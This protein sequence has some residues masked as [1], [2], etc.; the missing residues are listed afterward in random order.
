MRVVDSTLFYDEIFM[1]LLRLTI[2]SSKVDKFVI[3]EADRSHAGTPKPYNLERYWPLLF[4]WHDKIHYVKVTAPWPVDNA[5]VIENW[6][7]NQLVHAWEELSLEKDDIILLSDLDEIFRPETITRV[8]S[9]DHNCYGLYQPVFYFRFNY[10]CIDSGYSCAPK[11]LRY[12]HS[13]KLSPNE[14]RHYR[15]NQ[16]V[17]SNYVEYHHSGWHW[18]YLM[19]NAMVVNKIQQFAHQEFNTPSI[20]AS[21][22]VDS[23]LASGKDLYNRSY[24]N[25]SLVKVDDYFPQIITSFPQLIASTTNNKSVTDYYS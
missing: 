3:I 17:D 16:S 22:D 15:S 8:V 11:A 4:P 19:N 6:Q 20:T 18:S 10:L 14:W 12:E 7:R 24:C 5:W 1:L 25:W 2:M 21:V 9:T 13:K 23:L